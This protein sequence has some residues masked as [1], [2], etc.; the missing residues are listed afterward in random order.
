RDVEAPPVGERGDRLAVDQLHRE[1]RLALR[2][3][4]GIVQAR[5]VGVLQ[6]TEDV[7][8]ERKALRDVPGKR[9]AQWQLE[10]HLA[11]QAAIGTPGEP[12][13]PHAPDTEQAEQDVRPYGLPSE[14]AS[15]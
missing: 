3:D 8:L 4:A 14:R 13:L 10:R 9:I 15:P 6:A 1:V 12:H 2:R 7:A 11:L 5:D